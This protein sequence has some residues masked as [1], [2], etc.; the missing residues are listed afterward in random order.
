MGLTG[1][2]ATGR[3]RLWSGAGAA[4][5]GADRVFTATADTS[6]AQDDADPDRRIA[7]SFQFTP[8]KLVN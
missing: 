1:P 3:V 2:A 6:Y 7:I 5:V 8:G 4:P